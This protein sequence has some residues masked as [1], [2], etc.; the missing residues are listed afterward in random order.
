M[1]KLEP[2]LKSVEK[3]PLKKNDSFK[4]LFQLTFIN[5]QMKLS[6]LDVIEKLNLQPHP[7]GGYFTRIYTA[8]SNL[9]VNTNY[10]DRLSL[11]AIHYMLTSDKNIGC[12][13][14]NKSDIL[15]FH[16]GG[17]PLLYRLLTIEGKYEEVI[18]SNTLKENT[19]PFL[20]V[21]AGD[22]KTTELL[23]GETDYGM[24]SEAVTP[25]FEWEDTTMGKKSEMKNLFPEISEELF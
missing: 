15:H 14:K 21:K 16:Q 4:I 10:G 19:K 20:F 2:K 6:S 22:W 8:D 5:Y 24:V 17:N 9:K 23:D 11:T 7:E 12:W 18:L 13:H 25:G 3:I 1:E